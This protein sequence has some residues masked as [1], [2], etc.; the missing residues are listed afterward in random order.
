MDGG[1]VSA[2]HEGE[3]VGDDERAAS[4]GAPALPS[5]PATPS[6]AFLSVQ[7]C[8][9]NRYE[10]DFVDGER[11]GQGV[12]YYSTGAAYAGSFERGHKHGENV[13]ARAFPQLMRNVER[14][15]SW[16][17]RSKLHAECEPLAGSKATRF[18]S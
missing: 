8:R 2:S 10:G 14:G 18:F 17:V 9:S 15:E 5:V 1:D 16:M 7:H 11:H 13:A 12:F 4:P 6:A 3:G